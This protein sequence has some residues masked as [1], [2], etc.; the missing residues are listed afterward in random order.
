LVRKLCCLGSG[1]GGV[2][3]PQAG[4]TWI[5]DVGDCGDLDFA[6]AKLLSEATGGAWGCC[7]VE[8]GHWHLR[9]HLG[10][11]RREVL[12]SGWGIP[13]ERAGEEQQNSDH[14]EDRHSDR[15][16]RRL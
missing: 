2:E 12:W 8:Y 6:G 9:E 11:G 4:G 13:I 14:G 7:G 1:S 10:D 15:G 5:G 16:D 3:D